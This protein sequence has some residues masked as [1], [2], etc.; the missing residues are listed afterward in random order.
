M[1]VRSFSPITIIIPVIKIL[2]LQ[3]ELG[4]NKV[5]FGAH[6]KKTLNQIRFIDKIEDIV[7][8]VLVKFICCFF[9]IGSICVLVSAHIKAQF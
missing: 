9:P 3:T 8:E 6:L 5:R 2:F 1:F 7:P 4:D